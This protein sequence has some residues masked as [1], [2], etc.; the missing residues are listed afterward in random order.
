MDTVIIEKVNT[1][2]LEE[3]RLQLAA[4]LLDPT[5]CQALGEKREEALQGILNM[6][7][8][9]SDERAEFF[10]PPIDWQPAID[11]LAV[12]SH[13]EWIWALNQHCKYIS[14]WVD[15]RDGRCLIR[16]RNHIRI[17]MEELRRQY[18][19]KKDE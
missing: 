11:A 6:L 16:D 10:E 4:A 8:T 2:K 1:E 3:Q 18:T 14:L 9:W 17:S 15:T 7:D 12:V 13:E 19:G 5:V